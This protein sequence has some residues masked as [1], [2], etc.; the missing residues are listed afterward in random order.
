MTGVPT[1]NPNGSLQ[2]LAISDALYT[3][4]T[5]TC[6]YVHDPL[7]GQTFNYDPFGNI[8]ISNYGS[9]PGGTFMPTYN[10]ATNRYLSLPSGSPTYDANGN[11]TSGRR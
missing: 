1:W 2:Q 10:A 4:N 5:Q 3:G 7:W 6:H 11:L 9:D 8:S